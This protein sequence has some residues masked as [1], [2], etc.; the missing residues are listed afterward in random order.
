MSTLQRLTDRGLARPPRWLP[1]NVQYETIMGSVAYG[2]S[3][4]TSDVDV[5]GWAIP[6]RDD[7]FPHLRGEILGFGQPSKRFE[8]YQ[9]HHIE[10][11]DALAGHGRV[12]D[13]TIF[14]IVRFFALAMDNNPNVID[15]LFTPANCVLH[16]TRVGNLV[17]ERR[18]VFLHKGAWAKFKGYAYSQLHKL[19][20]KVPTG[21]RAELVAAHGFDTKFAY[22]V[23]RLISEVEQILTEGDMD[24]QRNNEQLKAIRRGEWTEDRLRGWFADKESHLE[25]VFLESTIPAVPDESA[26]RALLLDCLE[27]HYGSLQDCVVS[28]DRAVVA[29]RTIQAELDR[30]KDLL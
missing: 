25:R 7:V 8:V 23:V 16:S 22:H 14:G 27:D 18:R 17:R 9:E 19:A 11:R 21:K 6:P 2:V 10:D 28:P 5:Y 29:L 4:D 20:I 1:G 24:L 15:S 26:I 13:L 3:S 12:Y 30:V